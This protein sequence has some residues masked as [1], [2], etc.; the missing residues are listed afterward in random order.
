G[1]SA[2]RGRPPTRGEEL[3][4]EEACGARVPWAVAPAA[5]V[6]VLGLD[7]EVDGLLGGCPQRLV[8]GDAVGLAQDHGADGVAVHVGVAAA[9]GPEVAV[10]LLVLDEPV[11]AHL[12]ILGVFAALVVDAAGAEEREQ[13]QAGGRR[14]AVHVL[15]VGAPRALTGGPVVQTPVAVGRLVARDP[16]EAASDGLLG[17]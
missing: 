13:G 12:H 1:D 5:V 16:R 3:P 8:P 17:V 7:D 2:P 6:L 14:V 10:F 9:A 15:V 11:D 4:A